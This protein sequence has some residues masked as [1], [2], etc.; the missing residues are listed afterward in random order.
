MIEVNVHPLIVGVVR[1]VPSVRPGEEVP[2]QIFWS[3]RQLPRPATYFLV[4][5][6][7]DPATVAAA[8][9]ARL[10]S[11][12]PDMQVSKVSTMHSWL[13][14]ELVRPRFAAVLLAV[15][16]AVALVLATIGTYSLF[17]YIVS[18]QT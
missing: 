11:V 8:I 6:A 4:R 10:Q 16:A 2:P 13:S 1:D 5:T 15:F 9:R 12:D 18:R 7:G 14:R 3:N 17:T